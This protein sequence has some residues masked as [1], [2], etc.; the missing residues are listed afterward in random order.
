MTA[1]EFVVFNAAGREVDWVVPY[2]SHGTI[3]PGRYSVH[4]GHHDYEVRVPEGGRFEIRDRRA[5]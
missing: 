2:I 4:N 1:R 3:A 5:A